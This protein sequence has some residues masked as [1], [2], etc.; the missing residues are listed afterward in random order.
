MK[1]KSSLILAHVLGGIAFLS[2]PVLF[3]PDLDTSLTFLRVPPFQR[4]FLSYAFLLAFFYTGYFWIVPELYFKKRFML[5]GAVIVAGYLAIT[6]VP[7][8]LIPENHHFLSADGRIPRPPGGP[9]RKFGHYFFHYALILVLIIMVKTSIRLKR[10]EREKL[11]AE[12]SYLKAQINPHFLFNTLNSIYS[13]A[14]QRSDQTPEAVVKLSGMMR[15]VLN[16]ANVNFV[17]LEKEISYLEDYIM[18]QKLRIGDAIPVSMTVTGDPAGKKIAPL[19]LVPF[20]ENAFKHGVNAEE[21]SEIKIRIEIGA[22]LHFRVSNHKVH[23][24]TIEKRTG[25]G[26]ENTRQRL[27]LLY[28]GE[29]TLDIADKEKEFIVH[30]MLRHK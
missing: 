17:S 24:H 2:L 21:D 3:S 29:H 26:N 12:L 10:S 25:V 5:F 16:E 22:E 14:L 9:V 13:L 8:M 4:E 27:A 23:I 30:L 15:Y 19:I 1:S 28:P 18:L 11:N 7:G 6:F 20:V